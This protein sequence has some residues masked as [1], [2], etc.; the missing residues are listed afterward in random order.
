L[1]AGEMPDAANC[2]ASPPHSF[3]LTPNPTRSYPTR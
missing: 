1:R 2:T 3:S